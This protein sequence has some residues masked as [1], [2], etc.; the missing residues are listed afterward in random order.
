MM[1]KKVMNTLRRSVL[2]RKSKR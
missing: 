1:K 2:I